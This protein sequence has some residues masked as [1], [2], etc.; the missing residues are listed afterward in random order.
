MS[1]TKRLFV[2]GCNRGIGQKFVE[3]V[4]Q[5]NPEIEMH[6]TSRQDPS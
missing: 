5:R 4:Y 6:I 2:T 1:L 3:L